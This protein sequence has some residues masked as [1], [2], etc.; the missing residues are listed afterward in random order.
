M[1]KKVMTSKTTQK[2]LKNDN[3]GSQVLTS[4]T[5]NQMMTS[6]SSSPHFKKYNEVMELANNEV[7]L[8]I[9]QGSLDSD[10]PS[11]ESRIENMLTK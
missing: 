1:L 9:E 4:Q 10:L 3:M 6:S 11:I 2:I 5:I 8:A 7:T